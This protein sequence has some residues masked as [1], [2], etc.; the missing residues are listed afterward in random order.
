MTSSSSIEEEFRD[1][2]RLCQLVE[3]LAGQGFKYH[4]NPT[5]KAKR[6]ENIAFALDFIENKAGLQA[7]G[8]NATDI[9]VMAALRAA[10][11]ER[12]IAILLVFTIKDKNL[13]LPKGKIPT[14]TT[15]TTTTL[16]FGISYSM[17]SFD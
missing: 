7:Y 17:T 3:S 5:N 2:V 10:V 9:E 8:W 12:G 11:G 13:Q 15:T 16:H 4:P 1:G 14:T 6:T